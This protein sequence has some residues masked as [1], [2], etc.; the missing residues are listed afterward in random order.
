MHLDM[1]EISF[2]HVDHHYVLVVVKLPNATCGRTTGRIY[3]P[4]AKGVDVAEVCQ[5]FTVQGDAE[6]CYSGNNF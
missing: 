1:Q 4:R 3:V 5:T 6:V 2:C